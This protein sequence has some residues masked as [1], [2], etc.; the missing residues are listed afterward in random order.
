MKLKRS[1]V[2]DVK[3]RFEFLKNKRSEAKKEYSLSERLQDAKEEEEKMAAYSSQVKKTSFTEA[4]Q[5]NRLNAGIDVIC[6][7]SH[8]SLL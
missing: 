3:A 7:R 6:L 5:N 1:T 2:D 4:H 8:K